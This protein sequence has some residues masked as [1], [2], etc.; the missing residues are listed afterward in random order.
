MLHGTYLNGIGLLARTHAHPNR[1]HVAYISASAPNKPLSRTARV[2]F[3][4]GRSTY[5]LIIHC[6]HA[7]GHARAFVHMINPRFARTCVD[8]RYPS[9]LAKW[10]AACVVDVLR[11]RRR[12][13]CCRSERSPLSLLAQ[14]FYAVLFNIQHLIRMHYVLMCL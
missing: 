6:E 4:L 10:N 5:L 3:R 8:A 13:R 1:H 2:S 7:N 14:I 12:R 9:E 11:R